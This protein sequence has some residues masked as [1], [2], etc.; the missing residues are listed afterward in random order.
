[1]I[2]LSR[3]SIARARVRDVFS[4]ERRIVQL[5]EEP[6]MLNATQAPRRMRSL[7]ESRCRL[8]SL[9]LAGQ[10]PQAPEAACG[11]GRA[12]GFRLWRRYQEGGWSAL[13]DRPPVPK[14][15]AQA[16]AAI[17]CWPPL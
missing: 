10:S 5:A 1:M 2:M 12:T 17:S 15:A 14:S 9:A 3:V 6:A 7:F 16:F 8:L 11:S 13:A 4:Q